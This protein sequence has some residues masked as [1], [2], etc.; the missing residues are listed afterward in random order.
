M[1]FIPPDLGFSISHSF[2]F[3]SFLSL[4]L[5]L[6]LVVSLWTG[7]DRPPLRFVLLQPCPLSLVSSDF[8]PLCRSP[9]ATCLWATATVNHV[10]VCG[11]FITSE[12]WS[13]LALM[14]CW[15]VLQTQVIPFTSGRKEMVEIEALKRDGSEI[16]GTKLLVSAR[17]EITHW[18]GVSSETFVQLALPN[19]WLILGYLR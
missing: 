2:Q 5:W 1:Q 7:T 18:F 10:T 11:F 6:L 9:A 3:F 8:L 14:G 15:S 12:R 17:K 13:C 19:C 16:F 4:L